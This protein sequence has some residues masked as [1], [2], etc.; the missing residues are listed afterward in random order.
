MQ[1]SISL[2][3]RATV[4]R[5]IVPVSSPSAQSEEITMTEKGDLSAIKAGLRKVRF[6]T[7]FVSSRKSEKAGRGEEGSSGSKYSRSGDNTHNYSLDFDSLDDLED[8]DRGNEDS[9]VGNSFHYGTLASANAGGSHSYYSNTRMNCDDKDIWVYHNYC[10]PDAGRSHMDESTTSSSE[11]YLS[12]SAKRSIL[13]W[14]KRKFRGEPLLKKAYAE[15][16][17]DDID[18]DRRQLSSESDESISSKVRTISCLILFCSSFTF[19]I[20]VLD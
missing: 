15:D 5:S 8:S 7:E 4:H 13:P 14:R 9:S 12:Q 1:I 2:V 11:P 10:M 18:F 6:F 17:G 3:E 20:T 19:I 16:G